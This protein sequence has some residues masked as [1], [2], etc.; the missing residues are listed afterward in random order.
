ML[1]ERILVI[2]SPDRL[3]STMS[4]GIVSGLQ[5]GTRMAA[6]GPAVS[7]R[8]P[9]S[10][11]MAVLVAHSSMLWEKSSADVAG[12]QRDCSLFNVGRVR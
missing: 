3:T 6:L 8:H 12:N 1:G 11:V 4:T 7:F 9:L 2:G 5:R 10:A